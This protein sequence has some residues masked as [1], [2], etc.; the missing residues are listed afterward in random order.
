MPQLR[1][2]AR[3]TPPAT[4][5]E[6]RQVPGIDEARFQTGAVIAYESAVSI[7]A[8]REAV[9]HVLSDVVGWPDWLA[10][11]EK[12]DALDETSL[13]NGGRFVVHQPKLRPTTWTLS[14]IEPLESFTWTAR[15]PGLVMVAEHI[16]NA[17]GPDDSIVV[18][19]FS[20]GGFLGGL[21][22]RL[23]QEVT[24]SYLAQ[25]AAS[26]KRRVEAK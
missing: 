22:G 7:G 6:A 20:F 18:L 10:T 9:W 5:R 24:T 4:C 2:G 3:R 8:G 26:L 14:Q 21:V 17:Q 12:V 11:V 25:E 19:R 1:R 13:H 23:Y 15:S 16:I